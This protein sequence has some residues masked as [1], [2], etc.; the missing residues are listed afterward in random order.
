MLP[1]SHVGF[2]TAA[3]KVLEK[4]LRIRHI[5]YRVLIVSSLLPDLLDKPV[6]SVLSGSYAYESRA[7]GHALIFLGGI[8]LLMILQ[9]L[10]NRSTMLLP[11]FFGVLFHDIFDEMW[12]QPETFLWPFQGW[13]FSKPAEDAWQRLVHMG[14]YNIRLLDFLDNIS[15]LILLYFFM[16]MALGGRILEFL[17][18]GRL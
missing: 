6:S 10:W 1:L 8:A 4:G 12:L 5:D 15:V 14:G 18:K 11:V 16:K 13:Q 17:R 9:W 3:V 2:T 7:V